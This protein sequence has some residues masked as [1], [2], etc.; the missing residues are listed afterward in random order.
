MSP[1]YSHQSHS[2][3]QHPP[4]APPL[5]EL[6]AVEAAEVEAVEEAEVEAEEEAEEEVEADKQTTPPCPASDSA[7][8]LLKYL[9]EKERKRTASSLN[10][11][12]TI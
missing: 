9:W 1:R 2:A 5:Q 3:H 7:E 12:A 8:T 4:C 10:S 11:N 6:Q